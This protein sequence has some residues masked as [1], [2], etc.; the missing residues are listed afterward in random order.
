MS[1][2]P[3]LLGNQEAAVQLWGSGWSLLDLPHCYVIWVGYLSGHPEIISIGSFTLGCVDVPENPF[4]LVLG[5]VGLVRLEA[6]CRWEVCQP[7]GCFLMPL[8]SAAGARPDCLPGQMPCVLPS[9]GNS[10]PCVF[11]RE[12]RQSLCGMA[13]ACHSLPGSFLSSPGT[14]AIPLHS[15]PAEPS[16]HFQLSALLVWDHFFSRLLSWLPLIHL[17]CSF[18]NPLSHS[19]GFVFKNNPLCGLGIVSGEWN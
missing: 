16:V 4:C 12:R 18:Q 9:L 10:P 2:N 19:P 17:V 13:A 7:S 3:W 1:G 8:F 5:G 11:L 6:P 14:F 15:V